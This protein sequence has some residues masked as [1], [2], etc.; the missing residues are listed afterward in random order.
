LVTAV[1]WA[2]GGSAQSL[3]IEPVA[4]PRMLTPDERTNIAVYEAVNR[5]VVNITTRSTA[6]AG[7]FFLEVPSEGAGSGIVLDARGHVL[8]N[9]HVVEGAK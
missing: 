4:P 3:A 2:R 7:L 8:T 5:S 9:Y 1:V 6:P